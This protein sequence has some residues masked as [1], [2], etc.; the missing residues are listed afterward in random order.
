MCVCV[1]LGVQ[2]LTECRRVSDSP[3]A[4]VSCPMWIQGTEFEFFTG[5]VCTLNH[6]GI[7]GAALQPLWGIY[8]N[9]P[10]SAGLCYMFYIS[11]CILVLLSFDLRILQLLGKTFV[12]SAPAPA[13]FSLSLSLCSCVCTQTL[14]EA[15]GQ[16]L[17]ITSL[18]PLCWFEGWSLRL[19]ISY[20]HKCHRNNKESLCIS[21]DNCPWCW[22]PEL[23]FC[24]YQNQEVHISIIWGSKQKP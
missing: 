18:L 4:V 12:N 23:L 21:W 14:V 1:D 16:S 19:L 20:S 13:S 5:L 9:Y 8:I 24:G 7:S 17:R 10:V 22:H 11:I 3:A 15:R 2:L 6:W